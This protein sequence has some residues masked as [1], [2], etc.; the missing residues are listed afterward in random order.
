MAVHA[1]SKLSL[2]RS[3]GFFMNAS[4]PRFHICSGSSVKNSASISQNT[5]SFC[6]NHCKWCHCLLGS[7]RCL[8]R[9]V[10]VGIKTP[11]NLPLCSGARSLAP[12]RNAAAE[13]AWGEKASMGFLMII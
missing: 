12:Q 5:G 13:C 1:L 11:E 9:R 8:Q 7:L 3:P 4:Y 2:I 6:Q 10:L